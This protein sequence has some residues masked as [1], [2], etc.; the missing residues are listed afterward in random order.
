MPLQV[1]KVLKIVREMNTRNQ[2]VR[3]YYLG[4]IICPK[5][6]PN[7]CPVR[8]EKLYQKPRMGEGE[9]LRTNIK[10]RLQVEN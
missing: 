5:M 7:M 9:K 3:L 6:P 4:P 2:T 1:E 10:R 8:K